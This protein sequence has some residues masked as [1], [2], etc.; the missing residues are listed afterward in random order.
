[1]LSSPELLDAIATVALQSGI[2]PRGT[3]VFVFRRIFNVFLGLGTLVGV[4]VVGYMLYNAVKYRDDGETDD[5][6]DR[7]TLGELP[8]GSGGGRKLFTSFAL[9]MIIVV[10]LISW[11]YATLLF[12]ES[13]P[14]D[15]EAI[16]VEVT[17][18]QFG[19]TFTYPNGHETTGVLRVPVDRSIQ[20][21]VTSRD[22]WH[23]FGVPAFR[24]KSDAIPGQTATTWMKADETGTYTARCYEL[25]GAG[26]SYMTA[27]VVVMPQ[28]E[29]RAWYADTGNESSNA[30]NAVAAPAE[31]AA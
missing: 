14:P 26:H 12:V 27:R 24:V 18:F 5:D 11:T 22:V 13:G 1:M 19:W 23:H 17:G 15:S 30:T 31:V 4:V 3:R 8:E 21:Q 6:E 7:P 20:L 28:D 2:V 25:C 29:Y 16:G 9:S 10:S